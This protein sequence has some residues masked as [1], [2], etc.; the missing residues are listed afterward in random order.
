MLLDHGRI[1]RNGTGYQFMELIELFRLPGYRALLYNCTVQA[2]VPMICVIENRRYLC[3]DLCN[4]IVQAVASCIAMEPCYKIVHANQPW[5]YVMESYVLP[6]YGA[7]LGK[8]V[9]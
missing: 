3:L 9:Q 2:K 6:C 4:E 7:Q 1:L 8:T 5:S